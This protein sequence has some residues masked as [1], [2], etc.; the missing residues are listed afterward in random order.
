VLKQYAFLAS[1][2]KGGA[3]CAGQTIRLRSSGSLA[4]LPLRGY[5]ET[6]Y[7]NGTSS[8]PPVNGRHIFPYTL[9]GAV[10]VAHSAVGL[11]RH[12]V[13][14]TAG[15][16][17]RSQKTCTYSVRTYMGL[18]VLADTTT[19]GV[20]TR[21]Y[22]SRA[23][24]VGPKAYTGAPGMR[25]MPKTG[26]VPTYA[27]GRRWMGTRE[28]RRYI[29]PAVEGKQLHKEAASHSGDVKLPTFCRRSWMLRIRE[30]SNGINR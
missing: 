7:T 9:C 8:L 28:C 30:L 5:G 3:P 17:G 2:R 13:A 4:L 24:E 20:P 16:P 29:Q 10:R 23:S 11:V 22:G 18:S 19:S 26:A 14:P 25:S 27:V 6:G 21:R 15:N 1:A 12:N